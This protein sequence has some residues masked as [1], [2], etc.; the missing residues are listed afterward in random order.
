MALKGL[1]WD[2]CLVCHDNIILFGEVFEQHLTNL[3]EV[4]EH[5]EQTGLKLHPQCDGIYGAAFQ[6]N[7]P[8]HACYLL[9]E[10]PMRLG[11]THMQDLHGV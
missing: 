3:A 2:S 5:I 1:L 10:P 7:S 11:A 9:Q 6:Q 4:F 8:Q